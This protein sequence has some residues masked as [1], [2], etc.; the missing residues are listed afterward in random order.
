M[1]DDL[2][3]KICTPVYDTVPRQL[4]DAIGKLKESGIAYE[5]YRAIGPL[6]FKNRNELVDKHGL[7]GFSH[8]LMWDADI[9]ATP[10]HLK[11]LIAHEKPI[12]SAAYKFRVKHLEHY[13][14]GKG[15]CGYV[16]SST[17]GLIQ[18]P[19]VGMGLCLIEVDVF[20]K[21]EKPYFCHLPQGDTQSAEDVGF[22]IKANAEGIPVLLDCDCEVHHGIKPISTQP[23]NIDGMM[24]D[25]YEAQMKVGA[26][27]KILK[28]MV[29]GDN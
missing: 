29:I 27:L 10:V 14:A 21:I 1:R 16:H 8:V 26:V 11:K 13:V 4:I 19:F 15:E 28:S 23:P 9:L 7:E 2:R 22:C 5:W 25:A 17:E 20:D 6:I 24:L 3:L 18:V 12:V